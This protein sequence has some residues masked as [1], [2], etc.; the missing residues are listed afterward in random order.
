MSS[1]EEGTSNGFQR[2]QRKVQRACDICRRKKIR[3][4]GAQMLGKRCSNC[5][6]NN[7]DCTYVQ[8]A[9]KRAPPKAFVWLSSVIDIWRTEGSIS[10]IE[11][12]EL[13]VEQMEQTLRQVIPDD[14][15][16]KQLGSFFVNHKWSAPKPD[17]SKASAPQIR[18][19]PHADL[20][21]DAIRRWDSGPTESK[22]N[23][24]V[25]D[26]ED[27]YLALADSLK[28]LVISPDYLRFYGESSGIMLIQAANQLKEE[29]TKE[30]RTHGPFFPNLR[31]PGFWQPQ[32]WEHSVCQTTRY[33][34]DFPA[35][36]LMNDLVDLYFKN[37]NIFIPLLHRPTFERDVAM[38]LHLKDDMFGAVLLL[39]CANGSRYS[40]DLR[41][42]LDGVDSW[43]SCGWKW[44]DQVQA[45][46][47][48]LVSPPSLYDLQF[49]S[50][51][52]LFLLKSSAPHACWTLVG[53]GLRLAQEIGV[54]RRQISP[55]FTIE[56]ELMKR[57]FWVLIYIDRVTSAE[58]GRP[59]AIQ[60]E[61]F[62]LD[63]PIECDDEYLMEHP[64]PKKAFL[65]P[66]GRPS[67]VSAF[68]SCL[69]LTRLLALALRTIYS[70]NKSKVLLG[71]AGP[72][73][74]QR[75]VTELDSALNQ[76]ADSLPEHL[77][78]DPTRED[79]VFF[80]QSVML[81]TQYYFVQIL[82]HRPFIPTPN[83]P[84]P[85][86][87]PSLAICT[88]AAR[89]CSHVVDVQ[90]K[91]GGTLLPVNQAAVFNAGVVLL[92]NIW[93]GRRSGLSIDPNREM[94]D[95]HKCMH[96]LQMCEK[97]WHT[98]GRL[99]DVL[100][101][102]ASVGELPLPQP[103]QGSQNKRYRDSDN[104]RSA[105]APTGN[106]SEGVSVTNDVGRR[107]IAGTKRAM[108]SSA[109]QFNAAQTPPPPSNQHFFSLPMY[110]EELG[111][112][113]LHGQLHYTSHRNQGVDGMD[114]AGG[115]WFA[116]QETLQT[117]PMTG[118]GTAVDPSMS[119]PYNLSLPTGYP[120]FADAEFFDQLTSMSWPSG[121]NL[122]TG[123][124]AAAD[125]AYMGTDG[126]STMLSSAGDLSV[127][128]TMRSHASSSY[129]MG[130]SIS[131]DE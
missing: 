62:D 24:E 117:L 8:E 78:W 54:H 17:I 38:K 50:L 37:I 97:R 30:A 106:S 88:N 25:K 67:Y 63:M 42:L 3:C 79:D 107:D 127:I 15:V 73:W 11:G 28:H 90:R 82:V 94:A 10:Y 115:Y 59:C 34:Y 33:R 89:S 48:S 102:L 68:N 9:N 91:R 122:M 101:Q 71:L 49:Y 83:R 95:V 108:K 76:W 2:R 112:L 64:D 6:N 84:S 77:R 69:K 53:I 66:L 41:V 19:I 27:E 29:Y 124:G 51:S 118:D 16:R 87:F 40:D 12:L 60:D 13:K 14:D 45:A 81:Y 39:V 56:G 22:Q 111:R 116:S 105:S 128:N 75:I 96:V 92:L 43:T 104:S 126:N 35:E 119:M 5:S 72:Q 55:R 52:S 121:A 61:D 93:G 131:F 58:E 130:E 23:D 123:D 47:T 103:R 110:S 74:E 18:S 120:A 26:E 7:Y 129:S 86:S 31:R 21:V 32:P 109:S 36:D 65:Q 85:L 44:F 46:R 114:A 4:D 70:I 1:D 57:A 98:C 113:P 125:A 100:Y 80:N 20:V 99:W